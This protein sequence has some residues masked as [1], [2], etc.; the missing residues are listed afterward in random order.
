MFVY[1]PRIMFV[2]RKQR[3]NNRTYLLDEC[4]F[5]ISQKRPQ[6]TFTYISFYK[7]CLQGVLAWEGIL[8][9]MW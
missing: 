9:R 4:A 7:N 2:L 6:Q 1:I 5:L 8:N 3:I